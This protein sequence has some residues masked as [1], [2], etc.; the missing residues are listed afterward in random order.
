ME[1]KKNDKD[2]FLGAILI[3]NI[4]IAT[5]LVVQSDQKL[6]AIGLSILWLI[7]AFFVKRWE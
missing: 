7:G 2:Y 6:Y 3:A 5:G 1:E 4:Y